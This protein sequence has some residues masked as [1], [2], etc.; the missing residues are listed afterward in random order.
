MRPS[1][2]NPIPADFR[3]SRLN[4]PSTASII[5]FEGISC[6][7]LAYFQVIR[8]QMWVY[9]LY[10]I[11]LLEMA[12][13]L[14]LKTLMR[15]NIRNVT[16]C[17]ISIIQSVPPLEQI[18]CICP[19]RTAFNAAASRNIHWGSSLSGKQ[20]LMSRVVHY[21]KFLLYVGEMAKDLLKK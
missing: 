3:D 20:Y 5:T 4:L 12:C 18:C 6:T 15:H 10:R 14:L 19:H 17:S 7:F 8:G 2:G 1:D 13:S 21:T 9:S 16:G 11:G